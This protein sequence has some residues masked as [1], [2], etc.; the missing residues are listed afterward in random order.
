MSAKAEESFLGYVVP[1]VV[2][3]GLCF[4]AVWVIQEARKP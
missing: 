4:F 2:V 3:M 1:R